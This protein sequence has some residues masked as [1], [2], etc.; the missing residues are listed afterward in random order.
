MVIIPYN[1]INAIHFHHWFL[2]FNLCIIRCFI[3]I[4]DILLG[5]FI[6]L[7]IQGLTYKD[8]LKFICENPYYTN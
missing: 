3:Y 4:P 5:F 6:G 7:F 2:Y 8:R 1:R